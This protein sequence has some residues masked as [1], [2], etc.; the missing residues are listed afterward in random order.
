VASA[1]DDYADRDHQA[2]R[3][4]GPVETLFG[5]EDPV[6]MTAALVG[7]QL[8][9]GF[10]LGPCRR[11]A[12]GHRPPSGPADADPGPLPFLP[13]LVDAEAIRKRRCGASSSGLSALPRFTLVLDHEAGPPSSRPTGT[14]IAGISA[15]PV[16][17]LLLAYNR[18]GRWRPLLRRRGPLRRPAAAGSPCGLPRYLS[19]G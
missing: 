10:D 8:V 1:T 3:D 7:E 6:A 5:Q 9:H 2:A 11:P 14:V 4:G 19:V 16:P 12:L 18:I 13:H 15:Q 17:Y